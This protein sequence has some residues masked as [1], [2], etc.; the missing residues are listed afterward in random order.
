[1]LREEEKRFTLEAPLPHLG[2]PTTLRDSLLARLDR[3]APIREVAQIGACIGRE[4]SYELLAELSPMKDEELSEALEQLTDAGLMFRRGTPPDARFTFKHALVQDA[5]YDSLLKSK[6]VE[7]HARIA[8]LLELH[9]PDRTQSEP[10][11][12][13]HHYTVAGLDELAIPFWRKAG[14]LALQRFALTEA[15]AHLNKGLELIGSLPVSED[16]RTK[17][18]EVRTLLGTTWIARRGWAAQEV[19]TTLTPALELLKSLDHEPSFLPVLWGLGINALTR[20]RLTHSLE[21]A[22]EMLAAADAFKDGDLRL[23]GHA[24]ALNSHWYRGEHQAAREHGERIESLYDVDVHRNIVSLTNYDPLTMRGAQLSPSV[25]ML[26]YPDQAA[27]LSRTALE[28]ARRWNHPFN[29]CTALTLGGAVFDLRCEPE[30]LLTYVDEAERVAQA[31]DLP[32]FSDALAQVWKGVGWVRAGR[33]AEGIPHLRAAY[34]RYRATGVTIRSTHYVA[35]LAEGVACSGELDAGLDLLEEALSQMESGELEE[36]AHLPEVLRLR[37]WILL[38]QGRC[39]EA[40]RSLRAAMDVARAQHAKSWELRASLTLAR[41]LCE[42]GEHQAACELLTPIFAW[43]REGFD[44]KDLKEAKVLL[45]KL[46]A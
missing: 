17:E 39:D 2:I 7:L 43:F 37:G 6:R 25:W 28:H 32:F 12:L 18:L 19:G 15:V 3:L 11:L 10:E 27:V 45:E 42:R 8:R 30:Q 24:L 33:L 38:Q 44:T 14:E 31:Q 35:V 26:G 36:R 23:M 20:N 41:L 4:F 40:E 13:A 34:A 16:Q 46:G 21:R 5:A 22:N 29:L 1:L 9:F